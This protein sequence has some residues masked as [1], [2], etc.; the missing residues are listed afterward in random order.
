MAHLDVNFEFIAWLD[1]FGNRH[2][3]LLVIV[4]QIDHVASANTFRAGDFQR[5]RVLFLGDTLRE[6]HDGEEIVQRTLRQ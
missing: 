6:V 4:L 3:D 5:V 2:L 1:S